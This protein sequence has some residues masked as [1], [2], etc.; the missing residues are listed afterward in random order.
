MVM[1]RKE[2]YSYVTP[3]KIFILRFVFQGVFRK[4][5]KFVEITVIHYSFRDLKKILELLQPISR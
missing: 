3:L 4:N 2:N 1:T 5:K